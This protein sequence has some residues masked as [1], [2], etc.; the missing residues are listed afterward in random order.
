M[1]SVSE[2]YRQHQIYQYA[3][4]GSPRK[5]MTE[6]KKTSEEIM[7]PNFPNLPKTINPQVKE[8]Q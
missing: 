1:S 7:A 8:T 5:K 6:R 3:C 4:N 2:T